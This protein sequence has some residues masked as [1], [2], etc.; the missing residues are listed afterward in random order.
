MSSGAP[1]DILL[2]VAI[3]LLFISAAIADHRR[4]V[5]EL[6]DGR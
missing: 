1:I 4:D 2:V 5:R 6:R 3:A